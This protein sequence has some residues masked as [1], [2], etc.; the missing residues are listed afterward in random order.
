MSERVLENA[1][2]NPP[3]K[4]SKRGL[5]IFLGLLGVVALNVLYIYFFRPGIPRIEVFPRM[6][7]PQ[8]GLTETNITMC[9]VTAVV[10]VL[11][12]LIRVAPRA[13]DGMQADAADGETCLTVSDPLERESGTYAVRITE[14]RYRVR[15]V[16]GTGVPVDLAAFSSAFCGYAF[17]AEEAQRAALARVFTPQSCVCTERY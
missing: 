11:L 2:Q 8:W 3:K 6:I 4:K 5:W 7:L 15:R 14:G 13:L 1:V 10:A 12:I 9:I 16:S 17:P